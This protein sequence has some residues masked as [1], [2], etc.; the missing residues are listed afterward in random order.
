MAAYTIEDIELIRTKS[1]ISYQEAVALL[2]YHNGSVARALIDLERNGRLLSKDEQ[3]RRAASAP[4]TGKHGKDSFFQ[5]MY[6]HR[7]K[8]KKGD[9]TIANISALF[10]LGVAIFSP[11]MAIAAGVISLILGYKI[12]FERN[13]PEF[14]GENLN[15]MVRNA[16]ENVRTSVEDIAR[17]I[18]NAAQQAQAKA[19]EAPKAA[20]EPVAEAPRASYPTAEQTRD[21]ASDLE[22]GAAEIEAQF[23]QDDFYAATPKAPINAQ[24]PLHEPVPTLQVP[25]KVESHDGDVTVEQENGGYNS[26][27]IG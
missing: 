17:D 19:K 20:K 9:V 4:K 16:A 23:E 27:T 13:A 6:R 26:A 2:D 7:L 22:K 5:R 21:A 1:G 15:S 18:S 12:N 10:A 25:V 11:H 24:G 3:D 8:V 14:S